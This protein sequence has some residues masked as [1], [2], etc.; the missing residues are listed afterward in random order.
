[1]ASRYSTARPTPSRPSLAPSTTPAAS[2]AALAELPPYKKPSHPLTLGA[3]DQIKALNGRE[4]ALLKEQSKQAEQ[5]ITDAAGLINDKLREH[6]DEIA[7][8]KKRWE[9]GLDTETQEDEEAALTMLQGKVEEMTK[10]LEESIRGIIDTGVAAKRMEESLQW[11]YQHAPE[12]LQTEYMTQTSQRESLRQS[13]SQRARRTQDSDG[14]ADVDTEMPESEGP[15]PGPTPLDGSRPVLTGIGELFDDRLNR[16]KDEYT[17]QSL[18]LRYAENEVYASFKGI[19][20]DAR[21][22]DD[23]P[24]PKPDS[25]FTATGSPAPGVTERGGDEDDDDIVM[26]RATISTRCPLTFQ[27]FKEPW[28]SSKCPHTF[29]K[30]AILEMIRVSPDRV[31]AIPGRA[32][33]GRR[34]IEC[35]VPGCSQ[36]LTKDDLRHDPILAR[37][38]QRMMKAERE[39]AA[40]SD[41]ED[42]DHYENRHGSSSVKPEPISSSR[43]RVPATQQPPQSSV[44]EDLGSPSVNED[45]DE[46]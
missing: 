37:K 39:Q 20:H 10:Q 36:T 30:T 14:D 26:D 5:R 27:K 22:Q 7:K 19:V 29:E 28:T 8:R 21:F 33:T 1:M 2:F 25:W 4:I 18:L 40:E 6:E 12:R 9:R 42:V 15:T 32:N 23:R 45:E 41:H 31:D 24:L 34:A 38:L 35:P 46:L 3:Q 44:V 16:K 17:S 43:L 11:L 13:Q